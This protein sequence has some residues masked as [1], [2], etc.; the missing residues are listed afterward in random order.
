MEPCHHFAILDE[1]MGSRDIVNTPYLVETTSKS[2][3]ESMWLTPSPAPSTSSASEELESNAASGE[4]PRK[5]KKHPCEDINKV[6][7]RMA[8]GKARRVA[9]R[10]KR[11]SVHQK[12]LGRAITTHGWPFLEKARNERNG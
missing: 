7:A 8:V 2:T 9:R 12:G 5:A 4:N 6:D 10:L 3:S 11:E 1:F